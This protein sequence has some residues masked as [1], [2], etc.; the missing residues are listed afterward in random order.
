MIIMLADN[1]ER[2]VYRKITGEWVGTIVR[3]VVTG[4]PGLSGETIK[5]GPRIV[6]LHYRGNWERELF[7][8]K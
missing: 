6:E 7:E 8:V 4:K 1:V 3:D 2:I 5:D